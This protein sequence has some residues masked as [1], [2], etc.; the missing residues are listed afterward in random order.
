MGG[1]TASTHTL[2]LVHLAELDNDKVTPGLL[3]FV[4]FAA[5]AAGL[6]LLMKSMG[7]HMKKVDFTEEPPAAPPS[8]REPRP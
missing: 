6:W 2:A 8:P 7:K 1:V 4:V 5:I 3:G